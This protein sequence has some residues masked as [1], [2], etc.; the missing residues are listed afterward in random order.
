MSLG[1]LCLRVLPHLQAQNGSTLK[2]SLGKGRWS[3]IDLHDVFFLGGGGE[4]ILSVTGFMLLTPEIRPPLTAAFRPSVEY[5]LKF[6]FS[7]YS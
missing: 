2:K 3:S 5:C 7:F 4:A 1:E 6:G